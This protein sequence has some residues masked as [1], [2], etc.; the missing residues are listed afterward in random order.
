MI[1]ACEPEERS[2]VRR[3]ASGEENGD[4]TRSVSL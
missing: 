2:N 1:A 4:V 3:A